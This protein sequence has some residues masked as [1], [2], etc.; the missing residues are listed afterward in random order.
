MSVLKISHQIEFREV[1]VVQVLLDGCAGVPLLSNFFGNPVD[2]DFLV[3]FSV[4]SF[5]RDS[6]LLGGFADTAGKF[7][8]VSVK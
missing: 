6:G 7:E 5:S 1:D 4:T 8:S 3:L 2:V